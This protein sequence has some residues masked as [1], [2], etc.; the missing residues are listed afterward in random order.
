MKIT[1]FIFNLSKGGAQGVFTTMI[2]YFYDNGYDVEVVVQSLEDPIYSE[3]LRSGINV[4]SLDANSAKDSLLALVKYVRHHEIENAWVYGPE[5]AVNL[6]LAKT[7]N[8][9]K[10]PI[11]ARSINT[12]S[13]E[14]S[15]TKSMFRK[16]VTHSLIKLFYK[17]VDAIVAQSNQMGQDLIENYG[18]GK[19]KVEVINNALADK[20]EIELKSSKT[21]EKLDYILYAGRLEPQKG[22]VM[23]IQAFSKMHNQSISL[24]IVGDGSQK[25]ELTELCKELKIE[26]RVKF[27]SYASNLEEYYR[28]AKITVLTSFYEGFPNVLIESIACGTP[29]VAFDLPSGPN[30]IITT[31]N[32]VLVEYLNVDAFSKACD[33]A[34][35]KQW[36]TELIK[37]SAMKYDR[38]I[39]L[40]K[41]IDLMK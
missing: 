2:N 3:K 28:T 1:G 23:L 4:I 31:D 32:G 40:N 41:Y 39:I 33:E 12:L 24:Y 6:Y 10:F 21:Y 25:C 34:I 18:F 29:V 17:K 15:H 16:Y 26:N 7:I 35:E 13:V 19:N 30:E 9:Q 20:Y 27:I 14:F 36:N 8:K 11:Y 38:E 22:L 5:L 37:N